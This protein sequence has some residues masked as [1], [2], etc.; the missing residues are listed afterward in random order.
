MED[1]SLFPGV[2]QG[3]YGIAVMAHDGEALGITE[4]N[5]V[6]TVLLMGRLKATGR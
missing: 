1:F 3:C 4:S 6:A 2:L 5:S